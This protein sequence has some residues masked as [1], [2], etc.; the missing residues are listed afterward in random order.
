MLT[1]AV[2]TVRP[3]ASRVS[4]SLVF[5]FGHVQ[6][7]LFIPLCISFRDLYHLHTRM[8]ALGPMGD[9]EIG[10][11][12]LAGRSKNHH[13]A[14]ETDSV[15]IADRREPIMRGAG[16][17][18]RPASAVPRVGKYPALLSGQSAARLQLTQVLKLIKAASQAKQYFFTAIFSI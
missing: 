6:G 5:D 18:P 17:T 11:K 16:L 10:T 9:H 3:G 14:H 1:A 7:S 4:E 8:E 13:T 15:L 2:A 12:N